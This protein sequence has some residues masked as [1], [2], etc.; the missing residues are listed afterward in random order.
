MK[1]RPFEL[2]RWQSVW[3]NQVKINI[4]ESGVQ[5]LT[6][7]ELV[8]DAA[9][10][11]RILRTPL[12]YPQTNGSE[13]ARAHVAEM[14]PGARAENVLMTSGCSEANFVV[15]WALVEAGDEVVFM[16]PNYMQVIGVAE[17]LGAQVKPL[18]LREQLRWNFDSDELRRLVGPRTKLIAICHPNNPTGAVFSEELIHAVCARA[19]EVG[20]YVLADEVYRGAEFDGP[21][22]PTFWGRYERVLCTGGL[23]KAYGLPGLRTGWVVGPAELVEKLWGYHD[24]TSIGIS[25]LTDR[26]AGYALAPAQRKRILERTRALLRRNYPV[27]QAWVQEHGDAMRHVPPRAGAIAW[28]GYDL[29]CSS[30]GVVEELR[31]RKSVLLVPGSQF[32]MDGFLRIGFGGEREQLTRGLELLDEVMGRRGGNLSPAE[33][34]SAF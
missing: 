22:S 30:Q 14:Y 11:Q 34:G 20:A 32:G 31:R 25:I 27:V 13:E 12:G 23:S 6:V 21:L 3:E 8:Q 18:W 10:L 17:A 4:S 29:E 16:Q 33:A 1:I 5:P 24:Y 2:E 19:A 15:T 26:L 9:V 7:Q 28:V